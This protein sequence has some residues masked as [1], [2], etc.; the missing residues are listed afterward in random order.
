M[1]EKINQKLPPDFIDNDDKKFRRTSVINNRKAGW[2]AYYVCTDKKCN[3]KCSICIDSTLNY[4]VLKRKDVHTCVNNFSLQQTPFEHV[5]VREIMRQ[6]CRQNSV[7]YPMKSPITIALDIH[8]KYT[9]EYEGRNVT[10]LNNAAME[11]GIK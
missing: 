5:D 6:E 8:V 3:G 4:P 1:K 11:N 2:T 9:K 10:Y 7:E